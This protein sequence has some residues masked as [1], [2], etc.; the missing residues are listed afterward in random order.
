[1]STTTTTPTIREL[2][3]ALDQAVLGGKIMEA[4]EQYYADDVVM[5]EN[6][7]P[8]T[9]GK[10]ANRER[11]LQFVNSVE[12]FHGAR[13]LHKAVTGNVAFGEWEMD[14]SLKGVGRILLAQTVV[15]E[16]KNGQV[17]AERFYHA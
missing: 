4:F 17:V 7:E 14:V 1:M 13:V 10:A 15:R 2:D 9:I 11:E 3:D 16:W 5:Q 12:A 8:A 6:R